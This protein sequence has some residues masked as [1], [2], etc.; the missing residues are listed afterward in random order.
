MEISSKVIH[1]LLDGDPAIRWQT[2]RDLLATNNKVVDA[3]RKQVGV[4]GWGARLL[5]LQMP[6][7]LWG[8]GIYS[9]KWTSTT[10]TMLLLRQLGL[11]PEHPQALKGCGLL[12]DKGFYRDGGINYFASLKHSE[13]C[14]TG[15]ILSLVSYFQ[16]PDDRVHNLASHL[17]EQQMADGGWNCQSFK[18]ATHSSFHTTISVLEGLF[19]YEQ[20]QNCR[21]KR[22]VQDAQ[23]RGREFLLVHRL[24]KSHRSSEIVN[25]AMTRFSF[26]P[27][28]H[29]DILRA[30][31]Y[32]Q[33]SKAPQEERLE[34]A[35]EIVRKR[36]QKDGRWILQNRHPGRTF[37]ELEEVGESS[38]WNTLRALRVLKWWEKM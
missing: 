28:W 29:Y 31:D 37:F 8:G 4:T 12:L 11:L 20:S 38:R 14:V 33:A 13:T 22:D 6:S 26:P 30:L 24:F 5:A 35:I 15:M 18:G 21:F 32:F 3:E 23:Q 25:P 17:L 16:Y 10:Y 7:G 2:Y 9:P 27:R 34:E 1:W 36:R 19:E